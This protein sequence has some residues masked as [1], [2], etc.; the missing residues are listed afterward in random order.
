ME[1]QVLAAVSALPLD[2]PEL[3]DG[4]PSD[5]RLHSHARADGGTVRY[6][7]DAIEREPV[8]GISVILV[9]DTLAVLAEGAGDKDIKVSVLI[10]VAPAHSVPVPELLD[11]RLAG[12]LDE[13][14]YSRLHQ[15]VY[16]KEVC[17]GA[18]RVRGRDEQVEVSVVIEVYPRGGG[19]M[20][21]VGRQ[22][23]HRETGE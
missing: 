1:L 7:S 4:G 23:S 5:R 17:R 18:S 11:Q 10:V 16:V 12:H 3:P 6:R 20:S 19:K 9:K 13:S 15:L 8:V 21:G 14:R 2:L 22:R